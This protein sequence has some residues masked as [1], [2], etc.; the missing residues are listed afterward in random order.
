[1]VILSLRGR[2]YRIVTDKYFDFSGEV[3]LNRYK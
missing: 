2:K 1:M 3:I